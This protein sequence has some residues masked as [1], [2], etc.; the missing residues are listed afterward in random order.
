MTLT[1]DGVAFAYGKNQILHDVSLSIPRG[2]FV[3]LLGPN[4]SGKSTLI[5]SIARIN[6]LQTGQIRLDDTRLS[7]LSAKDHAKIV[8]Y[9]P[10]ASE[11][12]AALSVRDCVLLGRTPYFGIRP[13]EADWEAVDNAIDLFDL[14][15]L[16]DRPMSDLSGGQ[17][18]RVLIARATAQNP[19]VLVLDEP[20]SA[21]DL[22]YQVEALRLLRNLTHERNLVTVIAIH[23]LNLA[24]RFCDLV[25][26]LSGGRI[27]EF[28][29]T[30]VAYRK[31]LLEQVYGLEVDVHNRGRFME[32]QPVTA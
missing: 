22:R 8:S 29:T 27:A 30:Q 15:E 21:L 26:V 24:A 9:V 3:G 13:A 7:T 4:G 2:K 17:A 23:D 20:T 16:A 18:Q 10:Q 1:I 14:S 6:K 25:T 31:E 28:G 32:V 19:Q 11:F 12:S 5:K